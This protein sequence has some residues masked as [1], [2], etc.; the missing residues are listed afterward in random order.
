MASQKE[1]PGATDSVFGLILASGG[2]LPLAE[3]TRG[4]AYGDGDEYQ[5]LPHKVSW[6]NGTL[7]ALFSK[8]RG[9]PIDSFCHEAYRVIYP[10]GC[11]GVEQ[12]TADDI[13]EQL[14]VEMREYAEVKIGRNGLTF[15]NFWDNPGRLYC[16]HEPYDEEEYMYYLAEEQGW[17][18][19]DAFDCLELSDAEMEAEL[20]EVIPITKQAEPGITLR[21]A[22]AEIDRAWLWL[23][24]PGKPD[25]N[26]R[27]YLKTQGF[28]WSRKRKGWYHTNGATVAHKFAA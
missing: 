15:A 9:R 11:D 6:Y 16:D 14:R 7:C 4:R 20:A 24:F 28:R 27:D 18:R 19:S 17:Y 23:Y 5:D 12:W 26:T 8:K 2:L 22:N 13:I 25:E 21:D 10:A 3:P 1:I